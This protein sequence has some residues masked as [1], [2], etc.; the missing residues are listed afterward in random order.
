MRLSHKE[1]AMDDT[2]EACGTAKP[3]P[4]R[5]LPGP[6][7]LPLLGN[8]HLVK[9]EVLHQQLEGWARKYGGKFRFAITSRH[10]MVVTDPEAISSVLRQRPQL[11]RKGPRLVQVAKDLAFHGVFTAN[12]EAWRCQRQLV[13]PGLDPAHLRS[14]LPA[15]VGVTQ[16]LRSSWQRKAAQD[17]PIDLLTDLMRYTV[18]V[19]TSLAF[20][21]DLNTIEQGDDTAIQQH[22]NFIF[23]K[24]AQRSFAAFD[25]EHWIK[26]SETV[27]HVAALRAAVQGF[28]VS[29]R[30]LLS[31]RP[32]LRQHPENLIQSLVATRDAGEGLT[33]EDVSGNALTMLLAGED[34]T[35]NTL[36]WMV[37]LLHRHPEC[38]AKARDEID[39]VAGPMARWSPE[40]FAS[41]SYL[42]AC[43][44]ETMRLKPVAP[45]LV[46]Q[47]LRDTTI[48]GVR[49]PART[50]VWGALRSDSLK[51][52]FFVDAGTFMPE[53]WLEGRG[54]HAAASINRVALPFGAGP[55]VCPGRQLAMLEIKMAMAVLLAGFDIDS[56]VTASGGE[57]EERL[58]FTMAP[59][60]LTMRLR[61]R[62][63]LAEAEAAAA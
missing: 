19:T 21:Q 41:L 24:L 4:Y 7:R 49:V 2:A 54:G 32:E 56:V 25:I 31:R 23:P 16:R 3:I 37:W 62:T 48:A 44:N 61:V 20:G 27:R 22:L 1:P 63:T 17:Q 34:T 40:R 26:D 8:A 29:T 60:P 9:R 28:I 42:E 38:L 51:D 55:R 46:L 18:D 39:R 10:F 57:P 33:D 52:E 15:V 59:E 35:A 5:S 13:M 14:Y 58:S 43:A 11:F 6:K 45:S 36:A 53:R 30:E 47:A 50:L 12:D